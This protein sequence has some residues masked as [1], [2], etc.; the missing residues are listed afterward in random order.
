MKRHRPATSAC[1]PAGMETL[2]AILAVFW[3]LPLAGATVSALASML[4]RSQKD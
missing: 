1:E 3:G 2:L 4:M